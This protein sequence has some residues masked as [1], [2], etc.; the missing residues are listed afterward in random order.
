MTSLELRK[1]PATGRPTP[2]KNV[3]C[4]SISNA[5]KLFSFF[6]ESNEISCYVHSVSSMKKSGST[7]YFNCSLQTESEEVNSVCFRSERK[8]SLLALSKQKSSV[9]LTKFSISKKFGR[10]DVIIDKCTIISPTAVTFQHLD[11]DETIQIKSLKQVRADQLVCIKVTVVEL[12]PTKTTVLHKSSV[13][14]QEGYLADPT[15]YIKVILWG[16]H[17]DNIKKGA[18]YLFNKLKVKLFQNEMYLNIQRR[19]MIMVLLHFVK[20]GS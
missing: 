19:Q 2:Q 6:A 7:T 13:R 11:L 20:T 16:I 12:L 10:E 1:R 5:F 9:Q 18:T 4:T 3:A 14:K 17:A 8:E 15:G